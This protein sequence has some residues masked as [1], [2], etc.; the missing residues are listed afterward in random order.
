[1]PGRLNSSYRR[2]FGELSGMGEFAGDAQETFTCA[3]CNRVWLK[4]A[5][6]D[7]PICHVENLPIC[8]KCAGE[9]VVHG[10]AP[11]EKKLEAYERRE[12]MFR[13]MGLG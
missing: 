2:G 11:F 12:A 5:S 9:A 10:C 3:H 8:L 13:E 1:M 6:E 7:P 4:D